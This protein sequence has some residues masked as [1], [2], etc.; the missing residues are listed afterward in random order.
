MATTAHPGAAGV[1]PG[2]VSA[3]VLA[4][5]FS[6]SDSS[7][8][9][10]YGFNGS[11]SRKK[12]C[13]F[14]KLRGA[15]NRFPVRFD[16]PAAPSWRW[17]QAADICSPS[18]VSSSD[19]HTLTSSS[20]LAPPIWSQWDAESERER[21]SDRQFP[22]GERLP[23]TEAPSAAVAGAG[24]SRGAGRCGAG[25]GS[26]KLSLGPPDSAGLP[27]TSGVRIRVWGVRGG[28]S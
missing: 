1:A 7:L 8:H 4:F 15:S 11:P 12:R 2:P 23:D 5:P 21:P 3:P 22:Q 18:R 6:A 17:A 13:F 19:P 27:S 26:E 20:A 24:P 16:S 25:T 28:A 9:V 14:Q 10:K